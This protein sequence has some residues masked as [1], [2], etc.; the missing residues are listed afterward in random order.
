MPLFRLSRKP[1]YSLEII[2]NVA[3]FVLDQWISFSLHNLPCFLSLVSPINF[4]PRYFC[5]GAEW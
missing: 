2:S 3:E 1:G 5:L 4:V